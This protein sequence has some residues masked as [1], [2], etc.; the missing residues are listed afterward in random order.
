[1]VV[2]LGNPGPE[3][4][5][6]RHN[7]G[8]AV[9]EQLARRWSLPLGAVRDGVRR[10]QGVVADRP[11]MLI[12]PLL[13]MNRSGPALRSAAGALEPADLMVIHDDLD[14]DAGCVRVK[15]GGGTAGHRGLDSVVECFGSE[16]LRVRIGI[17]RP[18]Q[19]SDAIE[20]VLSQFGN[21]EREV[22][23]GAIKRAVEAVECILVEGSERAMNTF[24]SRLA[25]PQSL[26][27]E[28]AGRK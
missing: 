18:P 3:Y 22:I 14:L 13:Y 11:V 19:G 20:H 2:G 15:R 28:S 6:S 25:R 21:E 1:M 26:S 4:E 16:F 8:F 9:V 5:G 10:G 27:T 23:A 17:G 7:V 12:E 24:N